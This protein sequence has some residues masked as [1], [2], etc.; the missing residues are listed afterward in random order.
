MRRMLVL[1]VVAATAAMLGAASEPPKAPRGDPDWLREPET[2]Q[3]RAHLSA[4]ALKAGGRAIMR[5]HVQEGGALEQCAIVSDTR[6]GSG[7]GEAL[8]SQA[9]GFQMS[10][11][12]MAKLPPDRLVLIPYSYF[13]FDTG[14][15]WLRRPTQEELLVLWPHE[16]AKDGIGGRAVINC[17]VDVRGSAYDCV[18]IEENPPGK[19][20][21]AAAIGLA[22]QFQFRPAKL[23]GEAV[24]SA[25]NVPI[26][27]QR[28]NP[29]SVGGGKT[30]VNP[31]IA[32]TESPTFADLA[33]A[34]PKKARAARVAGR[35][36]LE[37]E[38]GRDGRLK[39][40]RTVME[41][42]SGQG[43]GHAAEDLARFF[44]A[45]VTKVNGKPISEFAVQIPIVFDPSVLEVGQPAVGVPKW[46]ALPSL[47][48][49]Q[50][51]FAQVSKSD[52]G[53][54]RVV[55]AC[56]VQM[57][58][59]VGDCEVEDG[60]AADQALAQAA[61]S[62]APHFKLTTWT[63]E[64]LPTVGGTVRIPLRYQPD[65]PSAP[66]ADAPRPKP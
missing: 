34:Y 33:A 18:A 52:A 12:G 45:P 59:G 37:C 58:G 39:N 64:G 6:A 36:N 40:C 38:F 25:L 43:F 56:K 15:D 1:G 19:G 54:L 26:N 24:I 13:P 53:A 60:K 55:L 31:A 3:I 16:A 49:T 32:W 51:A 4:E 41:A 50:A 47:A 46:A 8:L 42:P 10:P 35:A 22:Q 5:C 17:L 21:G 14:P 65:T 20:F 30:L 27:W 9:S 44:L 29:A 66:P 57:G 2:G 23:H 48:D 62:L 61:M 28:A 11:L 63:V 7:F